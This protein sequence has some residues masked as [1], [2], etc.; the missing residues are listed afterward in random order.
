VLEQFII[1]EWNKVEFIANVFVKNGINLLYGPSGVGKTIST[2]KAIN[3]DNIKPILIDFDNNLDPSIFD[4]EADVVD[5]SKFMDRLITEI[6]ELDRDDSID[7]TDFLKIPNN[8]VFII[9][10]YK[11]FEYWFLRFKE[12]TGKDFFK[13][14]KK[15][16]KNSTFIIIGHSKDLATRRDIPDAP[17]EF[18]NHCDS[19]MMLSL[20][21]EDKK[22]DPVPTLHIMKLRAYEGPS[23]LFNWQREPTTAEDIDKYIIA[24]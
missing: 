21:K 18:V 16:S 11:M 8:R 13:W 7:K 6:V 19:K 4:I 15:E 14:M 9:D 12:Q 2:M 24:S 23:M 10:T 17:E 22:S 5:G 3:R 1:K 20:A